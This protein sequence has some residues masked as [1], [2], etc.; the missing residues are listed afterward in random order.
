MCGLVVPV[1]AGR[2]RGLGQHRLAKGDAAQGGGV[3]HAE[4]VEGAA[5]DGGAGN[6]LVQEAEIEMG[7]VCN[8]DRALAA[9]ILDRLPHLAKHILQGVAFGI[10]GRSG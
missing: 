6:G 7:I 3:E 4:R 1:H 8:Q 2:Q 10:A 9:G 5:L